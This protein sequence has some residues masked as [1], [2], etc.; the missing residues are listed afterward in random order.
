MQVAERVADLAVRGRRQPCLR[1][2]KG[3]RRREP[4]EVEREEA[5]REQARRARGDHAVGRHNARYATVQEGDRE[6]HPLVEH[7]VV[8]RRCTACRHEGQSLG[9]VLVRAQRPQAE[10]AVGEHERAGERQ[11]RLVVGGAI[12]MP[13]RG[14]ADRSE[15]RVVRGRDRRRR[16]P[17]A[18]EQLGHRTACA[19]G[20]L[21]ADRARAGDAE[22]PQLGPAEPARRR[23]RAQ[24][25][26]RI[27]RVAER[28]TRRRALQSGGMQ[29]Q[30]VQLADRHERHERPRLDR[31]RQRSEHVAPDP[32]QGVAQRGGALPVRP[33]GREIAHDTSGLEGRHAWQPD[34]DRLGAIAR[35]D[36]REPALRRRGEV[37]ERTV[38]R[39]LAQI[40]VRRGDVDVV[41]IPGAGRSR[42]AAARGR[43]APCSRPGRTPAR[44]AACRRGRSR[45]PISTR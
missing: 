24:Q 34:D 14:V 25:R 19:E 22:Q 30:E 3:T 41:R 38:L 17:R 45:G 28:H 35:D 8:R 15:H 44:T 5:Q 7:V 20:R 29:R 2:G 43:P 26:A 37:D 32:A 11:D 10:P 39:G 1:R 31:V 21:V 33:A 18:P 9:R 13:D 16:S 27:R 42:A 40:L 4:L 6:A 12:Q 36:E 23:L